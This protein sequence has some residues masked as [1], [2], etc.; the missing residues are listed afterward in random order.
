M[1][2]GEALRPPYFPVES[3]THRAVALRL[4]VAATQPIVQS[5]RIKAQTGD[6][7][8]TRTCNMSLHLG[9]TDQP[10]VRNCNCTPCNSL[11]ESKGVQLCRVEIRGALRRI[12]YPLSRKVYYSTS[13]PSF[14]WFCLKMGTKGNVKTLA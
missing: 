10:L 1:W 14:I 12:Y 11:R 6:Y 4:T 9:S 13:D 7:G 8:Y 2:C 3:V 5:E